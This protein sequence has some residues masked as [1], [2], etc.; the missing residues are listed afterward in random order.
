[1][2]DSGP[3][4]DI[5]DAAAFVGRTETREAVAHPEPARLLLATLDRDDRALAAGDALPL[6]WHWLYFPPRIRQS[7]L[8]EDGHTHDSELLPVLP[9]LP[10]RMW[11]GSRLRASAPLRIGDRVTRRSTL[12]ALRPKLGKS[13][14]LLFVTLRHELSGSAGGSVVEEQD[15]VFRE[16]PRGDAPPPAP[17]APLRPADV[18]RT[19]LPTPPLLFRFSALTFHGHRIHSDHPYATEVEGYEG[20]VVHG[21]LIA[22]LMLDLVDRA[23]PGRRVAGFDFAAHRPAFAPHPLVVKAAAVPTGA[24]VWVESAGGIASMGR[25]A[26]ADA[27]HNS[28]GFRD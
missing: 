5:G 8:G 19:V 21:P 25:V 15:L 18:E 16:P 9:F 1:M 11:A 3:A 23:Y 10:R 13:G 17:A 27:R 22:V 12:A 24:D 28:T 20:L 4:F 7:R 26:F 2:A 6:L 14:R